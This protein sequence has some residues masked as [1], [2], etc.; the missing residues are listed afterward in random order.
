MYKS[1]NELD[2]TQGR[3]ALEDII[4]VLDSMEDLISKY[5]DSFYKFMN[6]IPVAIG[7]QLKGEGLP[8]SVIGGGINLDDMADFKMVSNNLDYKTFES[9]YRTLLQSLLDISNTPAVSMNKTDISN[10]S[11][12]S[13]KLLF[14][15]ASVKA[16]WNEMFMREGLEKRFEIIRK[17]LE[18]K[19]IVYSDEHYNTLD[20]VFRYAMPSNDK[21]VIDNIKVLH[22]MQAISL[23]SILEHSPYSKDTKQ[24]MD[25][26]GK[27]G[28]GASDGNRLT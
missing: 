25:R 22:D 2:N 18:L 8:V 5:T 9:L 1:Q 24:E 26:L 20:V 28:S 6:P 21:E 23:E 4:S 3:S 11:E 7:Q 13:I 14:S 17:L 16:G 19:G 10:L 15:L 27:Q 12:V